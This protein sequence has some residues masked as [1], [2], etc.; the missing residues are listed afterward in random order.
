[1]NG[2]KILGMALTVIGG[3]IGLSADLVNQ[4]ADEK[5]MKDEVKKEVQAQL[6]EKNK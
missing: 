1:M 6:A 2:V 5:A 4:S 3:L